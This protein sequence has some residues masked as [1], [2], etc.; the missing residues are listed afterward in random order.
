MALEILMTRKKDPDR[1]PNSSYVHYIKQTP[2]TLLPPTQKLWISG[3]RGHWTWKVEPMKTPQAWPKLLLN[4]GA[5]AFLLFLASSSFAVDFDGDGLPDDW[6]AQYGIVTNGYASS[7]MRGW[8]QMDNAA[9]T[10]M[11]DRSGRGMN[12]NMSG[13]PASPWVPGLFSNALSFSSTAQVGFPVTNATFDVTNSF[14]LSTWIRSSAVG[15][16]TTVARWSDA[17]GGSWQMGM[18]TNGVGRVLLIDVSNQ[19]QTVGG[20]SGGLF[21]CDNQWH[22]LAAAYD[23]PT[24]KVSVFVDG[25]LEA[26]STVTNWT[27]SQA[28][29]FTFGALQQMDL[30]YGWF[31]MDDN[32]SSSSGVKNGGSGAQDGAASVP[33]ATLSQPGKIGQGFA[34]N[35]LNQFVNVDGF[36]NGIKTDPNGTFAFWVKP[37]ANNGTLLSFGGPIAYFRIANINANINLTIA[38][39]FYTA[40]NHSTPVGSLPLGVWSH[41]VCVQDGTGPKIYINGVNQTLTAGIAVGPGNWFTY[42]SPSAYWNGRLGA[43]NITTDPASNTSFFNGT[44]DDI[45]YFKRPLTAVEASSLFSGGQVLGT[46]NGPFVLD[47]VRLYNKALLPQ[48][49]LQLPPTYSDFDNDGFSNLQEYLQGTSPLDFYNGK[50]PTLSLISGNNQTGTTNTFLAT[51]L[52]VQVTDNGVPLKNAPVQFSVKT[53]GGQFSTTLNGTLSSTLSLNTI[54]NGNASA[55]FKFSGVLGTNSV[56]VTALAGATSTS[57]VFTEVSTDGNRP[58]TATPQSKATGVDL[59]VK[60]TLSGTDPDN[61]PLTYAVVTQPLH[62]T[63]AGTAPNLTYTPALGYLGADSF[64]FSVNDGKVGSS[65]ATVSLTMRNPTPVSGALVNQVWTEALSPMLVTGTLSVS[66]L[67]INPGVVVLMQ[68]NAQIQA[69][70]LVQALGQQTKT[71][72]FRPAVGVTNGWSGVVLN[73]AVAG[74]DFEWCGFTGAAATALKLQESAPL[75]NH[76]WFTG[77]NSPDHGGALSVS[78][79][80]GNLTLNDTCFGTNT[81]LFTGGAIKASLTQGTLILNDCKFN[82]N[83]ANPKMYSSFDTAGGALMVSG[84]STLTRCSFQKNKIQAYTIYAAYGRYARGAAVSCDTGTNTFRACTFLDNVCNMFGDGNTPDY[85]YPLGGGVYQGSGVVN[86]VNCLFARQDLVAIRNQIKQGSAVYVATGTMTASNCTFAQNQSAPAI[87]NQAGTA[88]VMNS[89]LY[90]NNNNGAQY[91][92]TVSFNYCDMVGSVIGGT[93]NFNLNPIFNESF[94]IITPSPAIDTGNPDISYNDTYFPPSRAATRNDLGHFGGPG[95]VYWMN[96]APNILSQP[97]SQPV[98]VGRTVSLNVVAVGTPAMTYQ[99]QRNGV[100]ISGA[101]SSSYTTPALFTAD[102]GSQYRVIIKNTVGT[103]TSSV[104]VLKI[105]AGPTPVGGTVFSQ[106]WDTSMSPILVTNHLNICSLTIQPGVVIQFQSNMVMK[107]AGTL[108]VMGTQA[109]PVVFQPASGNSNGWQGVS[110]PNSIPGSE[111]HWC[112]FKGAVNSALRLKENS[113]ILDHCMFYDNKSPDGGGAINLMASKGDLGVSSCTFTNNTALL[114]GGAISA[115]LSNGTLSVDHSVFNGNLTNPSLVGGVDTQGGAVMVYGNS[116]FTRC[117]FNKNQAKG[118][119]YY[120]AYGRYVKGGAMWVGRGIHNVRGCSFLENVA[121]DY[122]GPSTPDMSYSMGGAI[123]Q[124]SGSLNLS[125]DLFAKN[126]LVA[127]GIRYS[128]QGSALYMATGGLY[129]ANCTFLQNASAPAIHNQSGGAEMVNSILFLN[130]QVEHNFVSAAWAG[131]YWL[132]PGGNWGTVPDGGYNLTGAKKLKFMARA[133]NA[134]AKLQFFCGG[135]TGTY[136]DS[137]K[138]ETPFLVLSNVWQN[139]EIDLSTNNLSKVSGG[140]GFVL[141]YADNSKPTV[142][143]LDNIVYDNGGVPPLATL[144]PTLPMPHAIYKDV[145]NRYIPSGWIGDTAAL[146]MNDKDAT[147]PGEGTQSVKVTYSPT[148]TNGWAGIYWLSPENNWATDIQGG[149]NMTGAKKVKFMAR[150]AT[151]GLKVKFVAGGLAGPYPDTFRVETPVLTLTTAWQNYEMDLTGKDL[152]RVVGAFCCVLNKTDNPAGGTFFVDQVMYDDGTTPFSASASPKP[153]LP[154]TIYKEAHDKYAPSGWM[155]DVNALSLRDTW[156][157]NAGEGSRCIRVGYLVPTWGPQVSG[158]FKI[159]YSDVYGE[160]PATGNIDLDPVF[161]SNFNMLSGSPTIDTGNPA[162]GYN[163]SLTMP[164]LGTTRNDM[165]HKGGP[166]AIYWQ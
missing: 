91:S 22:H 72:L 117:D 130:N 150:A 24:S 151:A 163:D 2:T 143:Y 87:H 129:A 3:W 35:G 36:M 85:S 135:I 52:K 8:W 58:P 166:G 37:T 120:S 125:N 81:A 25:N 96:G 12:G 11:V 149:Y 14:T 159:E 139:Y 165:G 45:R 118:L 29:G 33:T 40:V 15:Q 137:F 23:K 54:S 64:T 74:S 104:A 62:G 93:G 55:Y 89:I 83:T 59:P 47:E 162:S 133:E 122:P 16:T 43:F 127:G 75:I 113:P 31:A 20:A 121:Y 78:L 99:W 128:M 65:P 94:R 44:L 119:T 30:P 111:F 160:F 34:F 138:I 9:A 107:V 109:Q 116:M 112:V 84:N 124:D 154:Y 46:G 103:V 98:G 77:N 10:A 32:S 49:I 155:G 26:S 141:K 69:S 42:N 144:V 140:Y 4:H 97:L 142:F 115:T 157:L 1:V 21:L 108:K 126:N 82:E 60:I 145:H 86:L 5:R 56:S 6:E 153:A 18:G 123:Y 53:G 50:L 90:D 92:G 161:D 164:A 73:K 39:V 51:P 131:V 13:F 88:S 27:L 101:T 7:N 17:N 68:S 76:C 146:A 105:S 110:L 136:P 19:V 134:G 148:G 106:T 95:V 61:N 100:N 114:N 41:V 156:H 102:N 147:A 80:S 63:L 158:N 79:S 48:E 28:T 152:T 70:G 71:I 66:N 132:N 57:I 67:T 38:G